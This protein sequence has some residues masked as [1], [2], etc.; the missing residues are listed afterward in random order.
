M[1]RKGTILLEGLFAIGLF[2]IVTAFALELL[3][4]AQYHASAL[5]TVFRL[6]R[7]QTLGIASGKSV[8]VQREWLSLALSPF[9]AKRWLGIHALREKCEIGHGNWTYL[10]YRYEGFFKLLHSEERFQFTKRCFFPF[11]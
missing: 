1:N 3:R 7:D 5:S 6:N 9:E 11:S 10:R 8:S 2:L 4:M